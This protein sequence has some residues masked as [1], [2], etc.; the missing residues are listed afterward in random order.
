MPDPPLTVTPPVSDPD[1]GPVRRPEVPAG[2]QSDPVAD[3]APVFRVQ[4]LNFHYGSFLAIRDVS[5]DVFGHQITA[6]IGPSG[7]GKS[8]FL[9]CL[10]LSLIHI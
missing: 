2:R 8:T 1:A 3:T 10:N 4:G 9:R 7:C 6:V 5:I